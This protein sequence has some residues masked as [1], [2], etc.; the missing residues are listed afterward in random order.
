M[1]VTLTG[2]FDELG[3]DPVR[4]VTELTG[5]VVTT[6][7][8]A[9]EPPPDERCGPEGFAEVDLDRVADLVRAA[10]VDSV[11]DTPGGG[12]AV[13]LAGAPT[14]EPAWAFPWAVQLGPG[15]FAWDA[16]AIGSLRDLRVGPDTPDLRRT[17]LLRE[18]G[19]VTEEQIAAAV[20]T[21][22]RLP[23]PAPDTARD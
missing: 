16:P 8:T 1:V 3:I 15:R 13:L 14:V 21:Q 5:R 6:A 19:A 12:V 9:A 17:V 18:L 7:R 4:P 20:L 11:I 10:G 22:A 2:W 23:R